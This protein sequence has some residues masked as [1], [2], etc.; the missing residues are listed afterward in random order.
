MNQNSN[1]YSFIKLVALPALLMSMIL[2]QSQRVDAIPI[3]S[4]IKVF[5]SPSSSSD[6]SS[7]SGDSSSSG[8]QKNT[9]SQPQQQSPTQT[10]EPIRPAPPQPQPR[11]A[12]QPPRR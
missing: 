11:V 12:P 4:L 1:K 7:S 5:T 8:K 3:D 9:G 2:G 10:R 6:G